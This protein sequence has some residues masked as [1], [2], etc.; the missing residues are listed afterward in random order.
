MRRAAMSAVPFV[1]L[2][3]AGLLAAS[4][5]AEEDPA[6]DAR[7][8]AFDGKFREADGIIERAGDAVQNDVDLRAT[9]GDM[10]LKYAKQKQGEAK[11]EALFSARQHFAKVVEVKPSDPRGGTGVVEACGELADLEKELRH[12]DDERAQAKFG[13][14]WGE[15]AFAAGVTT[16]AFK[17]ALGR[18]YGRHA[19]FF[20]NMKD[21]DQLVAESTK[22]ATLLA[23]AAAAGGEHPGKILS[24]ASTIR[25][26]VANLVHEGVPVEAEKADDEALAAAID[27]ATQACNQKGAADGDYLAHLEALRLAHS[28]GMKLAVKP[29]MQPVVPPLEGLKLEVPRAPG[30]TREKPG[31]DWDLLFSRNLHE[32]KNDGAVQI[33]VKKRSA[34]DTSLGKPWGALSDQAQRQFDKVKSD[35]KDAGA[36]VQPAQLKGEIWHFEA[37]GTLPGSNPNDPTHV[38]PLRDHEWFWFADKKHDFVWCMKVKDW[39]PVADCAEPDIA[40]FVASAIGDGIWPPGAAPAQPD[41]PDPKKPPGKKK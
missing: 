22:G 7:L 34:N 36:V 38:R 28:W 5:V 3:A 13:L 4:A 39:R 41:K 37:S 1:V 19:G 10:A 14:D 12:G 32:P 11:R 17:L 35:F 26:R 31:E 40:A 30:W 23:E 8:A 16:P 24:E 33:F 21:K 25:L 6:R 27:L 9:I 18:M 15:K 2:A 29:F 20:K